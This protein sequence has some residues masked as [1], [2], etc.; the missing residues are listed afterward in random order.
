M[1]RSLFLF[2]LCFL[3]FSSLCLYA[4]EYDNQALR[5]LKSGLLNLMNGNYKKAIEECNK[6]IRIDPDSAVTYVL[7]ARAYF[8]LGDIDRAI[9]DSTQAIK[10]DKENIGAYLI[11]GNAYGKKGDL[12]RA[13]ADWNAI[14]K[15][16]PDFD[17]AKLNIEKA[18]LQ[19]G[20]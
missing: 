12:E 7:R 18:G 11:R 19:R 16:N 10:R 14:L 15:I 8:E 1:K 4:Q 17:D 3:V 9:A 5:Y 6:V 13:I 20:F 2:I